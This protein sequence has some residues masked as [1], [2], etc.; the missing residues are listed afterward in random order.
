MCYR[1]Y[2]CAVVLV[3]VLWSECFCFENMHDFERIYVLWGQSM[4]SRET[5]C[6]RGRAL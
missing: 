2:L 6:A 1:E 4:C 3:C 5:L